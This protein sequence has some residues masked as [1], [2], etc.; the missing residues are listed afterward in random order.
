M[1]PAP[2]SPPAS[3]LVLT[4]SASSPSLGSCLLPSRALPGECSCS[5]LL[6]TEATHSLQTLPVLPAKVGEGKRR[7]C[8]HKKERE[9]SERYHSFLGSKVVKTGNC[10]LG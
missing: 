1:N 7:R 6:Q 2:R 9:I 8:S 10:S 5:S 4:A 3:E